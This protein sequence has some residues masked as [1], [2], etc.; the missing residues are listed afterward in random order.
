MKIPDEIVA[1]RTI[2]RIDEHGNLLTPL[3]VS[4]GSPTQEPV[5]RAW[6]CAYQIEGLDEEF[7]GA[8]GIDGQQAMS[9]AL[10]VIG[11]SLSTETDSSAGHLRWA[12][13]NYFRA[14]FLRIQMT[15]EEGVSSNFGRVLT[16]RVTD[17]VHDAYRRQGPVTIAIGHPRQG[18][19]GLWFC[20]YRIEGRGVDCTF[21]A[22]GFDSMHALSSALFIV[23]GFDSH[24]T[25]LFV[26]HEL[27]AKSDRLGFPI[28]SD[29]TSV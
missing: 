18:P 15:T 14:G 4:L 11:S 29:A 12:G 16:E 27:W 25:E 3:V 7:Y 6:T 9:G 1:T 26:R 19:S 22:S 17:E 23:D 2:D 13:R 10:L 24:M 5:T 8:S 20:P 28:V 21:W